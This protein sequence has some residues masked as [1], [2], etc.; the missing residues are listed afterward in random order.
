MGISDVFFPMVLVLAVYLGTIHGPGQV[1]L[2]QKTRL[3]YMLYCIRRPHAISSIFR[4]DRDSNDRRGQFP[5]SETTLICNNAIVQAGLE[6][7]RRLAAS[8]AGL[9]A[10]RLDLICYITVEGRYRASSDGVWGVRALRDLLLPQAVEQ[11][12]TLV[13]SLLGL[14]IGWRTRPRGVSSI[15]GIHLG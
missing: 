1:Y 5:T 12:R 15:E 7:S 9:G 13:H 11:G 2:M 3:E 10:Q 6:R 8:T 4:A 14:D